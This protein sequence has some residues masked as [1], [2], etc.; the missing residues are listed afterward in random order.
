MKKLLI[1]KVPRILKSRKK[2][3]QELNIQISNRGKE[4]FIEGKPEDEFIAE[5][6]LEALNFGFPFSAAIEIKK[7]DFMF[8]VL[9]IKDYTNRKNLEQIRARIIGTGGRTLKTL[10]NISECFLELK[11]NE[12]G[13]IGPPECIKP[14]QDGVISLIQGAKQGNVYSGLE[15]NHPT[16]EFDLGLRN[17]KERL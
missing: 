4:F 12:I 16:K 7:N 17:P 8:E 2:L 10:S 9:N 13:I 11:D 6:V 1:E 15:K 5:K 3:E 14:A